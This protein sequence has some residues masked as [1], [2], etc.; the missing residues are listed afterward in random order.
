MLC[1]LPDYDS[2]FLLTHMTFRFIYS[3][4]ARNCGAIKDTFYCE[5]KYGRVT[6]LFEKMILS[7]G[8]FFHR[9]FLFLEHFFTFLYAQSFAIK[10][11]L[12][13]KHNFKTFC[14]KVH[15]LV[16]LL[17][18]R[19]GICVSYHTDSRFLTFLGMQQQFKKKKNRCTYTVRSPGHCAYCSI[20]SNFI[21]KCPIS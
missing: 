9:A 17:Y 8:Y 18:S 20:V 21:I 12:Q 15:Y 5:R 6:T 19:G 11:F 10:F 3:R 13:N 4:T 16:K 7:V 14:L 1:D 2:Q